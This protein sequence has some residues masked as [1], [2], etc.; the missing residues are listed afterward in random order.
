MTKDEKAQKKSIIGEQIELGN[1]RFKDDEVNILYELVKNITNL[2]GKREERQ[3][4]TDSFSSEGKF[5]RDETWIY[6]LLQEAGKIFIKEEHSYKDDD[7]QA[8]DYIEEHTTA[9][10]I[11]NVLKKM[12]K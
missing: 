2:N 8:G 7:G 1:G 12:K 9:R 6:T 5:H 10:D 3:S 11:L 4:H